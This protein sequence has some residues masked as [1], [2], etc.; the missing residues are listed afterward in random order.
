[1]GMGREGKYIFYL[2]SENYCVMKS[3]HSMYDDH[4]LKKHIKNNYKKHYKRDIKTEI[5]KLE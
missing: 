5:K 3:K 4:E 1:M 2:V